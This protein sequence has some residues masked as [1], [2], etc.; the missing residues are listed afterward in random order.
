[1]VAVTLGMFIVP[2]A[3]IVLIILSI[4]WVPTA[5]SVIWIRCDGTIGPWSGLRTRVGIG[6]AI[7]LLLLAVSGCLFGITAL[8]PQD[9]PGGWP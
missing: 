8:I 4:E 6:F 3:A 9:Y 5:L 1:M 2:V 7:A